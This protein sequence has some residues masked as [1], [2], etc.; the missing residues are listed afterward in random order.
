MVV[1]DLHKV[2]VIHKPTE[3]DHSAA[4]DS[5]KNNQPVAPKSNPCLVGEGSRRGDVQQTGRPGQRIGH[6]VV[7]NDAAFTTY[8]PF[9]FSN[10][11]PKKFMQLSG[12]EHSWVTFT[13][14]LLHFRL[15]SRH[16]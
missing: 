13:Q 7:I 10:P 4:V 16:A 3:L 5:D 14:T 12:G 8:A 6:V 1:Q 15:S 11:I 2:D 9:P